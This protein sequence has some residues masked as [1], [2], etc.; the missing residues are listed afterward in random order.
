MKNKLLITG[1]IV[2]A[3]TLINSLFLIVFGGIFSAL[4][5]SASL[6][7]TALIFILAF[8]T[9]EEAKKYKYVVLVLGLLSAFSS[10]LFIFYIVTA[11]L[12][13]TIIQQEDETKELV[14]KEK[15][16]IDPAIKRIDNILKLGVFLVAL[17]GL[18][19]ATTTWDTLHELIRVLLLLV[20]GIGFY[21]LSNF[22]K[23]KL[24]LE[25]S[26]KS[27]W[28]L[29]MMFIVITYISI[30]YFE[31]FGTWFSFEGSGVS[32][33]NSSL[34]LLGAVISHITYMR[35]KI[36]FAAFLKQGLGLVTIGMF[37]EFI[38]FNVSLAYLMVLIINT[39]VYKT[40]GKENKQFSSI[41]NV[42]ALFFFFIFYSSY[43][44]VITVIT[45]L[46]GIG[47]LVF[48]ILKKN[49]KLEHSEYQFLSLLSALFI[50]LLVFTA[51]ESLNVTEV[52]SLTLSAVVLSTIYIFISILKAFKASKTF[53][54]SFTLITSV[55][56]FI[57]AIE[58][59]DLKN[60]SSILIPLVILI[61]N[62]VGAIIIPKKIKWYEKAMEIIKVILL[63]SGLLIFV[64]NYIDIN[65]I[66]DSVIFAGIIFLLIF[67]NRIEVNRFVLFI[68]SSLLTILSV[69]HNIGYQ[70]LIPAIITS[71]LLLFN[72]LM[73]HTFKKKYQKFTKIPVF[74]LMIL[75]FIVTA[76]LVNPLDFTKFQSSSLLIAIL[77]GLLMYT[78]EKKVLLLI[79][80]LALIIPFLVINNDL[81]INNDIIFVLN[82]S[83]LLYASHLLIFT[84]CSKAPTKNVLFTMLSAI[85]LL[86]TVF[87]HGVIIGLFVGLIS[88]LGIFIGH[89]KE[90]YRGLF[91]TGIIFTLLNI[92][93]Q[94]QDFLKE[95][96][97][98]IY[99]MVA[100]LSLIA[101]VSYNEF[102]KINKE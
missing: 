10:F 50:N 14:V 2:A 49:N 64:R 13:F 21:F 36:N 93:Y 16:K 92:V 41:I 23:Q 84:T 78:K 74:I 77:V 86:V 27:Y 67:L 58:A 25:K 82:S 9:S 34:A 22:T 26:S 35:Y 97:L 30:G 38:G 100:G 18:I 71:L 4:L 29:S 55:S 101:F 76:Y 52:M 3:F 40:G 57:V 75:G 48:Y 47:S 83:I 28:V 72:Y 66:W 39:L 73:V 11:I 90:E 88:L 81:N 99:L 69:F 51:I 56:L 24:K 12:V 98:W 61:P 96:P 37:L 87:N 31:I 44:P 65:Y 15:K 85:I 63:L 79:N 32:L 62:I 54:V 43:S 94:L 8:A 17:A 80:K 20:F 6:G 89:A 53:L 91:Y 1:V 5:A 42:I 70:Q 46:Y 19:L 45:S 7:F 33:F 95:V 59:M 60:I 102:K 68:G